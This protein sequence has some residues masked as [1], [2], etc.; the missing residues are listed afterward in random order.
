VPQED[1]EFPIVVA[2]ELADGNTLLA[3]GWRIEGPEIAIALLAAGTAK[4][5]LSQGSAVQVKSLGM[6][7]RVERTST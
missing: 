5:S 7:L 2:H 1:G 6:R 3:A 4:V